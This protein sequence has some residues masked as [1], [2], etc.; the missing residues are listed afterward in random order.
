MKSLGY[1]R[2]VI[3]H[4]KHTEGGILKN[5]EPARTCDLL[6]SGD[7]L[8][9]HLLESAASEKIPPVNL[10]LDILY[11]DEDILVVNK[12]ADTPIHPSLNNYENTLANAVA[13][14]Y[15]S[16]GIPYVFRCLNRLDRDT[17]GLV[18]LAKHMLS[19]AILSDQML[20]RKISRTYLAIAQGRLPASGTIHAPIGRVNNS[21]IR[22]QV[23]FVHGERAVTHFETL[24][25]HND[26]SLVKLNLGTGRTH[27]IRVHLGYLGHPLIGDFLYNPESNLMKRQ[28]LHSWKL[29][30][31]HPI[32][33]ESLCFTAP[34]PEDMSHFFN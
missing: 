27:Q 21:A 26:L 7:I 14:H 28:A 10:P 33:K 11:E 19:G 8:E 30:F 24:S 13:Y 22:R 16:Q 15:D 25:Y 32:T 20:Q 18:L 23:D 4:L 34:L 12:A 2:H 31:T 1:S 5:Q 29:E 6:Y 9:I 3:I 17:T